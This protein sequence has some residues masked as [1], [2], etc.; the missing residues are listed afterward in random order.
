MTNFLFP[1]SSSF[2]YNVRTSMV[3]L[4]RLHL[5]IK[6]GTLTLRQKKKKRKRKNAHRKKKKRKKNTISEKNWPLMLRRSSCQSACQQAEG[7]FSR[8]LKRESASYV[9][10]G[11]HLEMVLEF[12]SLPGTKLPCTTSLYA[13]HPSWILG[14]CGCAVRRHK[15]KYMSQEHDLNIAFWF[16]FL[17]FYQPSF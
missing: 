5:F 2:L 11:R 7:V 4:P 1:F 6:R 14:R 8:G 17:G 15:K 16:L 9:T 3:L 10:I 13:H 12:G